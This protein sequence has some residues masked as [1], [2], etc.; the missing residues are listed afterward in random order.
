MKLLV[1]WV[2]MRGGFIEPVTFTT[3]VIDE[4]SGTKIGF[5]EASRSPRERRISLFNGKYVSVFE[6]REECYAFAK[7]VEAVLNHMTDFEVS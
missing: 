3:D 5:V 1:Q 6:S 4:T 2:D 7:G